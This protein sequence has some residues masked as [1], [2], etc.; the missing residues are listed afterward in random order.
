VPFTTDGILH[1]PLFLSESLCP[2][3]LTRK[4][5]IYI[6]GEMR[7]YDLKNVQ[8]GLKIIKPSNRAISNSIYRA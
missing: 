6:F 2:G 5:T 3:A 1:T 7:V 8:I 4:S